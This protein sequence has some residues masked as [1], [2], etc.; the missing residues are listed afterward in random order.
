MLTIPFAGSNEH[1]EIEYV[2]VRKPDGS[3]VD[4]PPT[5]AQELPQE[6]T[7]LAPFYS[8]LK[9]K[10]VPVRSLRAGDK[11]E[12]K[13]NVVRT[14]AESA[15]Q[16]WGADGFGANVVI[17]DAE[18]ELHIPK[19]MYVQVWS[20]EHVPVV[21]EAGNEKV[22][23][24][25]GSQLKPTVGLVA[26]AAK[27][28]DPPTPPEGNLA[29]VAWTT[30]KS[31]EA[32][33]A[34]YRGM[35]ADRA[36]PDAA[37]KAK[38]AELTADK[39]QGVPLT[40]KE[41]KRA[42]YQYVSAQIRYIGVAFGVGRYQP[43]AAGEVL[44]NQ[45]GDCKDKHTL[46]AAMLT[47]AG[48]KAQA[49]LIGAGIRM[50]EEVPSPAAF[51][52]LIT[53]MPEGD[54]TV[55]LDTTAEVSPYGLLIYPL[56]DKKA[57]V[58]PD[59]GVAKL[60]K[61]PATLPFA[62]VDKFEA[63]GALDKDGTVNSHMVYTLR[64]DNE[65]VVRAVLRQIA[66]GQWDQL[67]QA[68]SQ[69]MGFAGTTSHVEASPPDATTDPMQLTYDYERKKLGDW[70]N[71]KIVPLFPML[72]FP[73]VDEANPPKQPIELGGLHEEVSTTVLTLPSGW[74]AQLPDA[75]HQKAAFA[76]FDQS[77]LLDH[78]KLTVERRMDILQS[79][80]PAGDWKIYKKFLDATVTD[81]E[82]YIQLTSAAAEPGSEK[83]PPLAGGE[84]QGSEKLVLAANQAV[85]RRDLDSAEQELDL[86]KGL[87]PKQQ[88]LWS[89]YGHLAFEREQWEKAIEAYGKELAVYP[90][91]P[92]VYEAMAEAQRNLGR[93]E[94]AKETL[95]KRLVVEPG[96]LTPARFLVSLLL[97]DAEGGE[98]VNVLKAAVAKHP[99]NKVLR[100]QLGRTEMKAGQKSEGTATLVVLLKESTDAETLNDTAYELADAGV[101]LELAEKTSRQVVKML[102]AETTGWT[103]EGIGR[104]EIAKT[105]MLI[106]TWDTLGWV[107]FREDKNESMKEAEGYVR[108][109]WLNE[110]NAEVGLHLGQVEERLGERQAAL[111]TYEMAQLTLSHVVPI[112]VQRS[113]PSPIAKE[114]QQR[115][116]ALQQA[117]VPL[118]VKRRVARL[119]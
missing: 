76:S 55:W 47:A 62:A 96:E 106:A 73:T 82:R 29:P 57:L 98:A 71:Y 1:V 60:E 109:A 38:V 97:E 64:G 79:K 93:R 69:Q 86:A 70:D 107:L 67:V 34:W 83:G 17:L 114:L 45:Y 103:L 23:H 5:D 10:Q 108:A 35:E 78:G 63:T 6:V 40:D 88:G 26:E 92:W 99:D 12:Y 24:W 18:I 85:G 2:R 32:V 75:I 39:K 117:G 43:H 115:M 94:D 118:A 48:Y 13:V 44:R 59:D 7:R 9:E 21:S 72:S 4:T 101:E 61:T 3:V 102:T 74:S 15:G 116:D 81:G 113:R 33:G 51:N 105:S 27:K 37:V 54:K 89:A 77:Y 56:R 95:R 91:T 68:F 14:S 84:D 42:I 110:Q 112:G 20:P 119:G 50:N 49:A 30:F 65:V 19:G 41:K 104:A 22:Y 25:T 87:N 90:E 100:V 11:L 58:V 53:A 28:T 31:W 80:I 66:P 36:V 8:D 52:H 111:R 46:L 16:F